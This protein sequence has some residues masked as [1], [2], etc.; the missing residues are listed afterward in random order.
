LTVKSRSSRG[1]ML[2]A[3]HPELYPQAALS[4]EVSSSQGL[5]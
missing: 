3:Q 2:R 5:S 4:A 1:E